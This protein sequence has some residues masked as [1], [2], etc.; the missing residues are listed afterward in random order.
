[1]AIFEDADP[2]Q[3]A[4][5][6]ADAALGLL[7][8]TVAL[9]ETHGP[10]RLAVH[11]GIN[12][13]PALVGSTRFEGPSG[14]RWTFTASGSV[15]NLAARLAGVAGEGQIVAGPETVRRLGERYRLERLGRERLKN[16]SDAIDLYRILG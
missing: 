10:E 12:S 4:V 11:I 13:G 2:Q 3:H 15:T 8:A 1:M 14:A 9:N 5:K 7:A 6:T 16:I